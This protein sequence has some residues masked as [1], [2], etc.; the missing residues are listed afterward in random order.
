MIH[1][2]CRFHSALVNKFIVSAAQERIY[3]V[4]L[5]YLFYF[6]AC[7]FRSLIILFILSIQRTFLLIL[8]FR[9]LQ[10]AFKNFLKWVIMIYLNLKILI[11]NDVPEILEGGN[12]LFRALSVRL[13]YSKEHQTL[14]CNKIAKHVAVNWNF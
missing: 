7:P 11:S 10:L 5:I 3:F 2:Y 13:Y 6:V 8:L 9:L 4:H 1:L 14:I 12:V